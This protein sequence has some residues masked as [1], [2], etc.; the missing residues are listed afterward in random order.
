MNRSRVALELDLEGQL[1]AGDHHGH[2]V[3]AE[4]ARHEDTIAGLHALWPERDVRTQHPDPGSVHVQAVCLVALDNL[5]SATLGTL[6]PD[7]RD[8][9]HI[10]S[11]AIVF[12]SSASGAFLVF[13]AVPMVRC[14]AILPVVQDLRRVWAD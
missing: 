4:R 13:G 5:E 12:I 9:L 3:V 10:S 11:G 7:I 8:S 2:A 6:S 14:L 1:S